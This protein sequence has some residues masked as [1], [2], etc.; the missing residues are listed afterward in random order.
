MFPLYKGKGQRHLK[1]KRH[2]PIK[3]EKGK[4]IASAALFGNALKIILLK[5]SN[6]FFIN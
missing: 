4:G 2:L 3:N 5:N 1:R 6:I